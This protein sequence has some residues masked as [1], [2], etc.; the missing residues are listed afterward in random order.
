MTISRN[1][2]NKIFEILYRRQLRDESIGGFTSLTSGPTGSGKTSQLFY[3]AKM[4]MKQYP[5]EII[6]FRDSML[7]ASNF[8]RIGKNW[9]IFAEVGCNLKFRNLSAKVG[10]SMKV[11]YTT[12]NDFDEL[13]DKDTGL[14]LAKPGILNVIYFKDDYRWIDL[15]IHLRRVVGWQSVFID[16]IEDII[17]LNPSKREGETRNMRNEKNIEF[18]N[19]VKKLRRGLV[20]LLADTQSEDEIDWRFKRKL[21]FNVYLRGSR[22][23]SSTRIKQAAVDKL[24][25][26]ECYI[27]MENR[28]YGKSHF[29]SF[30]P[31]RPVIEVDFED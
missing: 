24:S 11:K 10:G 23:S 8:N 30:P 21:N 20:N 29:S 3:E 25:L 19:N 13:L 18:S 9:K 2:L 31:R 15:L 7:S 5:K 17:P 27:D 6:F 4:F 12:F 16:E 14:G 1:I 22:V 26:G 28:I